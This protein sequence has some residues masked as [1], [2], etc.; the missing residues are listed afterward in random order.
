LA[1]RALTAIRAEGVL[2]WRMVIELTCWPLVL[3]LTSAF[4]PET[5]LP[6]IKDFFVVDLFS[7]E[8][9]YLDSCFPLRL[10]PYRSV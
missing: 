6:L 4:L 7:S 9:E 2:A 3:P 1:F 8:S 10:E 5:F